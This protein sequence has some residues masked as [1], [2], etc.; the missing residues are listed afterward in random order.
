MQLGFVASKI[1]MTKQMSDIFHPVMLVVIVEAE[2]PNR[3][4]S[5]SRVS[6]WKS[7]FHKPRSPAQKIDCFPS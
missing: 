4:V 5:R 1:H 6:F 2:H 3:D 7:Y